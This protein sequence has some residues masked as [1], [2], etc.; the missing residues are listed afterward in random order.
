MMSTEHHKHAAEAGHAPQHEDVSFEAGSP[1]H[2]NFEIPS[3]FGRCNCAVLFPDFGSLS[4]SDAYWNAEYI[5]L[6]PSR[7]ETGP[8][9]PEPRLQG[10][11]GHL[12][13]PIDWR[14]ML[15][16]ILRQTISCCG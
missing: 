13:D 10:M 2:A 3:L 8:T 4:R 6:P 12:S 14:E 11:P 7:G 5:S 9:L 1:C 16:K 15:R